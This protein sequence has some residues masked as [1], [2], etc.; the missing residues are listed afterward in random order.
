VGAK[1]KE[2][3]KER[4]AKIDLFLSTIKSLGG[5]KKRSIDEKILIQELV[6]TGKFTEKEVRK[7]IKK[8]QLWTPIHE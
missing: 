8:L 5:N 1:M 6:E 2:S 3:D 7:Y 4:L